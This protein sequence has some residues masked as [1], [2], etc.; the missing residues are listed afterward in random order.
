MKRYAL[1]ATLTLGSV[2]A[3]AGAVRDLDLEPCINGAVSAKGEFPEQALEEI[4]TSL[5]ETSPSEYALEPCINGD[6]S[7]SGRYVNQSVEDAI[8]E[9]L[10]NR[11]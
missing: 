9:L 11:R 2:L 7:A 6:V 5:A 4:A 8:Q 3:V 10:A 1:L